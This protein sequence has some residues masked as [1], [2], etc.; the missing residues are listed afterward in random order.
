MKGKKEKSHV[1]AILSQ[2]KDKYNHNRNYLMYH[3]IKHT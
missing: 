2:V 3:M 1:H